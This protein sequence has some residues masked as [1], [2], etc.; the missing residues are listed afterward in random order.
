ML[1]ALLPLRLT[2]AVNSSARDMHP[3]WAIGLATSAIAIAGPSVRAESWQA[4]TQLSSSSPSSCPKASL[5]YQLSTEGSRFRGVTPAG[6]AFEATIGAD[7]TIAAEYEGDARAGTVRI[8]G[9][10]R[11]RQLSLTASAVQS[12][13]YLLLPTA[14]AAPARSNVALFT[15]GAEW[16]IGRWDGHI[17]T[18]GTVSGT[19]GISSSPRTLVIRRSAD[20]VVTCNW[21]E[22]EHVLKTPAYDCKI[23]GNSIS[24]VTTASSVVELR[25]SGSDT[26]AGTF[27][28]VNQPRSLTQVSMKR[29]E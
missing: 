12:C 21:A 10:A 20:G 22:P 24:L 5:Q 14:A 18:T 1:S 8:V 26:I 17:Y 9:N 28:N 4:T 13:Q 6:K 19:Q 11:S 16:S 7:G 15:P 23:E 27:R 2:T 29:S 25:R 3:I